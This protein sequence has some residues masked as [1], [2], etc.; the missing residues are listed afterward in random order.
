[1][2]VVWFGS[3]RFGAVQ[4]GELLVAESTVGPVRRFGGDAAGDDGPNRVLNR[5]VDVVDSV[6]RDVGEEAAH[7]GVRSEREKQGGHPLYLGALLDGE[8][9]V[10]GDEAED[11][12]V[13]LGELDEDHVAK[14]STLDSNITSP[15]RRKLW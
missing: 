5:E 13:L 1:M 12:D 11:V 4:F 10:V 8:R 9:S 14:F 15:I 3:E 6:V 7:H 2:G